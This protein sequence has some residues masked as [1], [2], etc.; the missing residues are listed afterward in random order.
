MVLKLKFRWVPPP[1]PISDWGGTLFFCISTKNGIWK[2]FSHWKLLEY[3][4]SSG[5]KTISPTNSYTC[6]FEKF[7]VR[8]FPFFEYFR[9]IWQFN[10]FI[11]P[12]PLF[13]QPSTENVYF[14]V[15]WIYL[16]CSFIFQLKH[17]YN[18]G[19]SDFKRWNDIL[20][21]TCVELSFLKWTRFP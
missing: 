13:P 6:E 1:N 17:L 18:I 15:T 16:W 8:F 2:K 10:L 19:S 11:H 12:L 3:I 7:S 14:R 21:H 9:P 20:S 4:C 5:L